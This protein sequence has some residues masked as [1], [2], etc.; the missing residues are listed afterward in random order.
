LSLDISS[1]DAD[2]NLDIWIYDNAGTLTLDFTA[3][4]ND[5]LRATAIVRQD[6]IFCKSGALN[7]R[8]LGTVRTTDAG[9]TCDTKLKRLVWNYYNRVER[10]FYITEDTGSWTYN[11]RSWRPWHNL[12]SNCLQF[13]IGVDEDL[14]RLQFH[15]GNTCTTDI[16]RA[17]GIGL[18][19][20]TEPSTDSVWNS[21]SIASNQSSQANYVGYPGIGFHYLQLLELGYS[22]VIT[23][24]GTLTT[25]GTEMHH[26][27]AV[28]SLMG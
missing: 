25:N 5:T 1:A 28:G 3:W 12:T 15:A 19:S 16:T 7:Y 18:D 11:A 13:V 24:Y 2:M 22:T 26:S 4:S 10:S 23:Y 17:V 14:V 21:Q 6:G 8:Y 9:V 20:T 27:G